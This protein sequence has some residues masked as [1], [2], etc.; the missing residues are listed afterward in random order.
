MIY[1]CISH[2][3]FLCIWKQEL[4][5]EMSQS[6]A[7]VIFGNGIE[8]MDISVFIHDVHLFILVIKQ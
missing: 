8:Q 5:R 3:L 2:L 7:S 4:E 6:F 1:Y